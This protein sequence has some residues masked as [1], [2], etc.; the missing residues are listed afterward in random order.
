[1]LL[2]IIGGLSVGLV[3]GLFFLRAEMSDDDQD[4]DE[5]TY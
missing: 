4:G 3:I 1:M 2:Y 5:T